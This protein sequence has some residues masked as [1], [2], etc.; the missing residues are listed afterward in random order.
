MKIVL[1]C[2]SSYKY[3]SGGKVVRYITKFLTKNGNNVKIVVLSKERDDFELDSFYEENDV[4]YLP[5]RN[6]LHHRILRL[7]LKTRERKEF[8]KVLEEFKPNIVHF[9]SFDNGKP[10]RFI[11]DAKRFGAKVVLQPWTMQFFCAQGFGFRDGSMCNLCAKGNYLNALKYNCINYKGIPTLIEKYF[12]QKSAQKGVV[13]LSS[14]T[15]LDTILKDYGVV[16]EKIVRFPIPFDYCALKETQQSEGNYFVFYGQANSHKGL[17][18]LLKVFESLPNIKLKI[19]PLSPLSP[20][21]ISRDNI[22]IVNNVGWTNGLKE[23]IDNSKGVL[24]PSL[25]STSTEYALCEALLLKKPVVIFNVGV[26]KDI[27]INKFN[28]M[29]V[30]PNDIA[31]FTRAVKELDENVQLRNILRVNGQRTL[32]EINNPEKLNHELLK[33]YSVE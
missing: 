1:V 5:L 3:E 9:A 6:N 28:A 19:C 11:S 4:H 2:E 31:G 26:H 25:W 27:F 14:N 20:E 8:I 16:Q 30:E 22:E 29:V 10:P 23:I 13:L 17:E 32:L 21:I 18:V 24:L 7:F 15:D 12:L 33:G